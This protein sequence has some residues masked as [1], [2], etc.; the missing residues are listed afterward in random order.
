MLGEIRPGPCCP[1]FVDPHSCPSCFLLLRQVLSPSHKAALS[2]FHLLKPEASSRTLSQQ[3]VSLQ[4]L[5]TIS[6]LHCIFLSLLSQN[7]KNEREETP[8]L[9]R[10]CFSTWTWIPFSPISSGPLFHNPFISCLP[11]AQILSHCR[12]L[13]SVR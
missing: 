6:N 8:L 12:P 7:S 1:A 11:S 10:V 3:I 2:L 5:L 9:S 13:P 4:F